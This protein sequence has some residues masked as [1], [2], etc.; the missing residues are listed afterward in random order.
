MIFHFIKAPRSLARCS[1][2]ISQVTII[3]LTSEMSRAQ[4]PSNKIFLPAYLSIEQ[5]SEAISGFVNPVPRDLLLP[6]P[7][8]EIA[9]APS[10]EILVIADK[11]GQP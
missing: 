3:S 9:G 5:Y 1:P 4:I 10:Y 11:H 6:V 8:S 7:I 2:M